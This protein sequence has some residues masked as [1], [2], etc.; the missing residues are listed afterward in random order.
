MSDAGQTAIDKLTIIKAI[1]NSGEV[2][3]LA[4]IMIEYIKDTDKTEM[5]FKSGEAKK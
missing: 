5:G 1:S 3:Q 4:K 2:Q